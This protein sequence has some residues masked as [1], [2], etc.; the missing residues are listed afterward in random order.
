MKIVFFNHK[1]GVSKTTSTFN[2]GWKLAERGH[3]VML[4]DADPQCNL[5]SIIM[6]DDFET[7]YID[8]STKEQNLRDGVE[9]AFGGQPSPIGFVS[10]YQTRANPNLLLLAGHPNLTE[11]EPP[12]S[13][14][15]TAPNAFSTLQNLPGAFNALIENTAQHYNVEYVLIDLNPGLSAINQNLFSISDLFILPTNPDPFSLM[16]IQTLSQVIPRWYRQATEMKVAFSSSSY[17]FPDANP[18]FAGA[19]IQRYNIRNGR[20][21]RS[22]ANTI[23]EIEQE[24]QNRLIPSLRSSGMLYDIS[25]YQAAHIPATFSLATIP[26]FQTLQQQSQKHG[27]P[28][29]A[30]SN[31]QTET[32]GIILEQLQRKRQDFNTL[33][34]NIAEKI[35]IIKANA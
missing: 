19:I 7:Y 5:T 30:L 8:A 10:C 17:P 32:Q 4:V 28:V 27:V 18:K 15:Q 11:R 12:L 31:A 34:E 6:Q 1:G 2:I 9:P 35:E 21:A 26:D 25:V 29:F 23:E 14:A 24:I 16:A 20:P 3:R 13:F 33:F 22:F